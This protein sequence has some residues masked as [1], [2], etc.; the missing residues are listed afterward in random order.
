[1]Q[2]RIGVILPLSFLIG[3]DGMVFEINGVKWS[4]VSVAPSSNC[5]RRSNGSF[6]V[7][8][9]DKTTHCIC[10]SNRLVG[11]FKRKVLIH[12]LCHAVCMS[13]NIHIP[14]EQEEFLCDFVATYGDEV[15][16]I[17]DMMVGEIRKTA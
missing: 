11:G 17:V 5:L 10:L 12:E 7:G 13:Y 2:N 3:G 6:T 9:T 15:F 1:M 16:D 8:V 4:V 14:L